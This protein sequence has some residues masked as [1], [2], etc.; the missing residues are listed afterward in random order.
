M[1]ART[2]GSQDLQLHSIFANTKVYLLILRYML[3]TWIPL[4]LQTSAH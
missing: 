4:L 1:S 3:W 2:V